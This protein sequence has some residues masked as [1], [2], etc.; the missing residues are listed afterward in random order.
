MKKS[1]R[2]II[3]AVIIFIILAAAVAAVYFFIGKDKG[4]GENYI[5]MEEPTL[6]T[7][8]M[9]YNESKVNTLHGYINQMELGSMREL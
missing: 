5:N 3:I 8:S 4:S 6:P 7:V 2:K 1:G 9:I